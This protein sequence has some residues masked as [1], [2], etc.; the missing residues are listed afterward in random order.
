MIPN[1]MLYLD[2]SIILEIKTY[3]IKLVYHRT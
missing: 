1:Y 3:N 2:M